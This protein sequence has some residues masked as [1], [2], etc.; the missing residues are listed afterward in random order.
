[1]LITDVLKDLGY[2]AINVEDAA[3]GLQVLRSVAWWT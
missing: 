3:A 2:I 1:M